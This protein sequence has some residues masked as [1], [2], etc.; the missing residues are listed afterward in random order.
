MPAIPNGMAFAV[1]GM[2]S[3]EPVPH[4]LT[5]IMLYMNVNC[6]EWVKGN[7]PAESDYTLFVTIETQRSV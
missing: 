5:H 1:H 7:I 4:G 3:A 6:Q 2:G